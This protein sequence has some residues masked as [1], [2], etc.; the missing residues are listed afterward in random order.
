MLERYFNDFVDYPKDIAVNPLPF[1]V[2]YNFVSSTFLNGF[3]NYV[4]IRKAFV[5]SHYYK[6]D[7]Y[8]KHIVTIQSKNNKPY[9]K[10]FINKNDIYNALIKPGAKFHSELDRDF[11]DDVIILARAGETDTG[12]CYYY[13]YYDLDCSDCSISRFIVKEAEYLL[14]RKFIKHIES[15][16]YID[17]YKEIPMHYFS[18]WIS[19]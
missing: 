12:M 3:I 4:E 1:N 19:G 16:D 8:K 14:D 9:K 17:N 5:L 18:G 11:N 15:F 2:M 7:E 10:L 6:W 13:F